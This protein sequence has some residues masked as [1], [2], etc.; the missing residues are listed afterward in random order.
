MLYTSNFPPP[1]EIP[2]H[3]SFGS[4]LNSTASALAFVTY[5]WQVI[6]GEGGRWVPK[7][8]FC[9]DRCPWQQPLGW[10][11]KGLHGSWTSV[12]FKQLSSVSM[13]ASR[14]ALTS[15]RHGGQGE[16]TDV[17]QKQGL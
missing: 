11:M 16:D 6:D 8:R 7:E 14:G 13:A 2:G 10:V 12:E 4:L 3:K 9:R 17:I 1:G 5:A 15:Q